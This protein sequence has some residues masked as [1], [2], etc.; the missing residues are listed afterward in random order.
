[1]STFRNDHEAALARVAVLEAEHARLVAEN[2]QL[3]RKGTPAPA[4]YPLAV[5]DPP[6]PRLALIALAVFG[7]LAA[8]FIIYA[9]ITG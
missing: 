4:P 3:R 7:G 2:Q 8:V 5:D 1:M 9:L 6:A